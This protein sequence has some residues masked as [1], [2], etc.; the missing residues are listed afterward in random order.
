VNP[1]LGRLLTELTGSDVWTEPGAWTRAAIV[2][3]IGRI[4]PSLA[5]PG[6][7]LW[8]RGFNM[9]LLDPRGLPRYFC[10]CRPAA[11]GILRRASV[12]RE[13]LWKDL[14]L[15]AIIPYSRSGADER[16]QVQV[17]D[18]VAGE[19]YG[20]LAAR[21]DP[22]AW[23]ASLR[24]L[25]TIAGLF[26]TRAPAIL[27]ELMPDTQ[28]LVLVD[29]AAP[30][31]A[32][33]ARAGVSR[34]DLDALFGALASAGTVPRVL[35]H[36]DLSARNVIGAG[37]SWWVVDFE[38]FGLVQVPLYD[39]FQL[40][41]TSYEQRRARSS[42]GGATWLDEMTRGGARAAVCRRVV[43]WASA[44]HG[45]EA[46][47]TIGALLFYLVHTAAHLYERRLPGALM[48]GSLADVRQASRALREGEFHV[49]AFLAT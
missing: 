15:R 49:R 25:V 1:R 34:H 30:H 10:K 37:D 9:Y 44:R 7:F 32:S 28:P 33:L 47:Q 18:Y 8:N 48:S 6:D 13:A 12:I 35:Q 23:E 42:R 27:P 2:N 22:A 11:D 38:T 17:S 43:S 16:V 31:R 4:P 45:L 26:S 24:S 21:S 20:R 46:E 14:A 39:T 5:V 40:L 19:T 36:G 29:A 41:R 3:S